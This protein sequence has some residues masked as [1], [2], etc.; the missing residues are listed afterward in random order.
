MMTLI[1]PTLLHL[2]DGC[3]SRPVTYQGS[4]IK[5][6]CGPIKANLLSLQVA[7]WCNTVVKRTHRKTLCCL[8][9]AMVLLSACTKNPYTGRWQLDFIPASKEQSMGGQAYN[10]LMHDPKVK[11]SHDPRE[12]DPVQRVAQ[13][14]IQAA[15]VSKYAETAKQ[16]H[17]EVTVIKDDRTM[18]AF[19]LPGGKIAVYTGIFP[20]AKDEAGLAAVLGHEVTHA[21]ARHGAERM[22]QSVMAEAAVVVAGVG[23]AVEGVNPQ[24]AQLAGGA[25]ANYGFILPYSRKHEAEADH[26]GIILM[27][28][29][30][31]DPHEAIGLWQRMEQM[32]QG[33]PPEFLSTHPSHGHRIDQIEKWMPE[34]MSYYHPD[35]PP[36]NAELPALP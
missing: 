32:S 12:V 21:L 31:Y 13:R 15:E 3:S 19:A 4:T 23:A 20:V 1:C 8:A 18:N 29:A 17:W 14:I 22:S 34:A 5:N 36:S 25:L 35:P 11:M 7:H 28:Q 24:L 16:F 9:A 33:Q 6:S 2:N 30:G 27:A 26:I 10:Q